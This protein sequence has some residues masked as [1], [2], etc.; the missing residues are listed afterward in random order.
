MIKNLTGQV[1]GGEVINAA[2]G[3]DFA[4]T[5]T[6]YITGDGG[7]QTIG[8]V[9]AGICT[10]EGK[11]YYTY[12]PSAAETNYDLIAFTFTGVGAIT[13]TTQVATITAAQAGALAATS[14]SGITLKASRLIT[15]ALKMIGVIAGQEVPTAD[16]AQDGLDRLNRL[17][18]SWA[19][20]R[21]TIQGTQR[22][23]YPLVASQGGPSNAYLI[24]TGQQ[25]NQ[26]RPVWIDN[27]AIIYGSGVS[28]T[29]IGLYVTISDDEYASIVQKDVSSTIPSVLYYEGVGSGK[30]FLWPVPT[31]ALYSIALYIPVAVAQ[32]ANYNTT[33]YTLLPGYQ[34]AIETNLAIELLPEYPRA[35][36]DPLLLKMATESLAYVKR[37]NLT[38]G[39][40]ACDRALLQGGGGYG[41]GAPN[42]LTGP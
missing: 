9:G 35:S 11:G 37:A 20:Q 30:I 23:T 25:F 41:P 14:T 36:P 28:A 26:A 21:G 33:A 5:V 15:N 31:S 19:I 12:R 42:W 10:L 18:D 27:A 4:G 8:S 40:L 38:P 17:I 22:F 13:A 2:T 24:G 3:A 6:V 32:F 16:Q 7:T 1:I 34:K 39:L 29:E